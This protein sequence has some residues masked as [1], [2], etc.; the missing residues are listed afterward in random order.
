M[1]TV[2]FVLLWLIAGL[3]VLVVI[4][5]CIPVYLTMVV[6]SEPVSAF[7]LEARLM[8]GSAP[9]LLMI[10]RQW[11]ASRQKPAEEHRSERRRAHTKTKSEPQKKRRRWISQNRMLGL[12][13]AIPQLLSETLSAI[14][15]DR[16][17]IQGEFGLSDPADTGR[18]FGQISPFIYT[19]FNRKI[20][21]A[22]KPN[23]ETVGVRGQAEAALHFTPIR[24]VIP[25]MRLLWRE[26]VVRS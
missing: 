14:H 15:I 22:V 5:V 10:T 11:G 21:V 17:S 25:T 1:L 23:F 13:R 9:R 19:P 16:A 26:F 7:C 6:K 20:S 12:I 18:I 24:L 8:H 2:L 4:L 3:I